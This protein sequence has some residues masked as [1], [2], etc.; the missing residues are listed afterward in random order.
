M[1]DGFDL[2]TNGTDTHLCLVDLRQ[3]NITGR[4]MESIC[5]EANI[6]VNRNSILGEKSP[7]NPSGIRIGTPAVTTRGL[8]EHNMKYISKTMKDL[9]AIA[10]ETQ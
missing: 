3:S 1:S 8:K 6:T 5:E 2:I 9:Y 4:I 10:K 7:I